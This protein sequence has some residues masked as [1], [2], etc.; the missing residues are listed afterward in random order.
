MRIDLS[1]IAKGYAVD[2]IGLVVERAGTFDYLAEIGGELRARGNRLKD[3]PWRVGIEIPSGEVAQ[4]LAM[5]NISVAS[6]GSY[7]NYREIDGKRVS[8]LIDGKTNQPISHNTVAT[9]V[10]H[11]N[12]MLA[13]AWATA[14]MIVPP[15]KAQALIDE[16]NIDVQITYKT[17]TG[18]NIWRTPG[19]SALVIENPDAAGF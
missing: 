14:L 18:F 10:L 19:F 8:H 9:T 12:T 13:D 16:H 11:R 6:S 2:R 17:D 15:E 1:S 4:G 3:K 7:R 5:S